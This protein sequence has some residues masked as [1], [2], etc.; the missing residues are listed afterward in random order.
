MRTWLTRSRGREGGSGEAA[1]THRHRARDRGGHPLARPARR[2]PVRMGAR[3]APAPRRSRLC[4]SC[5]LGGRGGGSGRLLLSLLAHEV[6]HALVARHHGV[7]TR[8]IT[9]FVFGG[10]T[11][12]RA[13]PTPRA[14]T[15]GSPRSDRRRAL[16]WSSTA[17]A[18]S[19]AWSPWSTSNARRP[20]RSATASKDDPRSARPARGPRG[21][22]HA[23]PARAP[24]GSGS[25]GTQAGAAPSAGLA[26]ARPSAAR[27]RRPAPFAGETSLLHEPLETICESPG[28]AR[29]RSTT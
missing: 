13:R 17:L 28:S 23:A 6:S 4:R 16:R 19:P 5:R 8:S 18:A 29:V 1:C 7:R 2:R 24:C 11:S 26:R 25:A 9:L 3:R 12:S 20:T 21:A 10:V 14:Q 22:R 27:P 15:S